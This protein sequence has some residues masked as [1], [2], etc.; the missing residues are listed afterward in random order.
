MRYINN[1]SVLLKLCAPLVLIAA[2]AIALILHERATFEGI[3]VQSRYVADVL[4]VRQESYLKAQAGV[5]EATLLS[6]NLIIDPRKEKIDRYK[7]RYDATV[8]GVYKNI[9]R[10]IA[11]ADTPARVKFGNDVR[12]L[13]E[14]Y[15]A[16]IDRT[17]VLGSR[18]ETDAAMTIVQ[19][20]GQP[21]R[22]KLTELVEA[23]TQKIIEE[24]QAGASQ[25]ERDVGTAVTQLIVMAAVGLL[26][27]A[28][29]SGAIVVFGITRPLS[30]L[31]SVLNRMAQG[32]ID[33][34][35]RQAARGDEIGAVGRA[36][37]GIKTMVARKAAE[38]AERRQIAETAA[39]AERKRTMMEL[40]DG[41]EGA[42]G[43]I[44]GMVSS[45]ATELQA[46]AQQM[47][48]TAQRT[49]TRSTTVASA[50]EEAAANVNTVASAAEEL[51]ASVQ[52]IGRQVSGSAN[53]AQ[54]AVAEADETGSHVTELSRA[55]TRIGDVVNLIANI[56]SQ[57]NLLA[58]NATIEAARAG[59]AGRGFAVVAAE[60]KELANQT[61]RATEEISGQIG[62]IQG[63][64]GQAVGAIGSITTR[65]REINTVTAT[66]A[67]AVEQQ[68]AAT[69]EI[70][71]NVAEASV[72]TSEVTTNIGGVAEASE[73]TGAAASQVLM[74]ASELSRQSE[75]L[76]A[77]V[78]R[79]L[80]T[81]RAA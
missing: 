58:L 44:V 22:A 24:M 12:K 69:Q 8:S 30:Q 15:F 56:A 63:A 57:T 33:S 25:L 73:E 80:A 35:I 17:I 9:D 21:A 34:T 59:E 3:A 18:N 79:F 5:A 14:A 49:A 75:H 66:I 62:Q 78:N 23:R 37:E 45:S 65:I 40:A 36:V 29:L 71:R 10:L 54:Q 55:V 81:I 2:M 32:E 20:E 74:S 31:V 13:A 52:E 6:R 77:E 41:F 7:A 27:A 47:T 67:A 53:L 1:A 60:V 16:V 70:V 28:V 4:T 61:A 26:L 38:D 42:V 39:A 76:S 68:G 50:A 43:G 11:L 64:T 51:G 46:T 19:E 72:G 48:S